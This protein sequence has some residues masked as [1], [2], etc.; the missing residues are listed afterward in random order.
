MC[1][2]SLD[3][4]SWIWSLGQQVHPSVQQAVSAPGNRQLTGRT[5]QDSV[6]FNRAPSR[7]C[8]GALF[9][10]VVIRRVFEEAGGLC[11]ALFSAGFHRA[12]EGNPWT[13]KRR[14]CAVER[15][16]FVFLRDQMKKMQAGSRLCSL[17]IKAVIFREGVWV[18]S[19][20]I[21]KRNNSRG[22]W[23]EPAICLPGRALLLRLK[24]HAVSGVC[25]MCCFLCTFLRIP[26]SGV[27]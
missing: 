22:H 25:S 8:Q 12:L 11:S 3:L 13:R 15:D 19:H 21:C 17:A 24:H 5:E 7:R 20:C 18:S 2:K 26:H 27:V 16:Y 6:C 4:R 23:P 10:E 14:N 9:T 1:W